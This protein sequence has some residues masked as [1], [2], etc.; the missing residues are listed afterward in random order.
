MM[1]TMRTPKVSVTSM[2]ANTRNQE[3]AATKDTI[4]AIL[5]ISPLMSSYIACM[6]MSSLDGGI[7]MPKPMFS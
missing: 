7:I 4:R 5:K 1:A 2:D 6:N 3:N